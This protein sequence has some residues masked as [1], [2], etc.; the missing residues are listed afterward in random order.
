MLDYIWEDRFPKRTNPRMGWFDYATP[1]Y[2]FITICTKEKRCYFG[3]P[4]MLNDAGHVA[5]QMLEEIPNHF[6]G[7]NVDKFV[8]MPNH[9]HAILVLNDGKTKLSDIIGQYKSAVTRHLHKAGWN[10]PIWQTSFHDHVIRDQ[11]GYEK[12]WTY[13]DTNPIRWNDDCFYTE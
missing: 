1:G 10:Q 13:I 3:Q 2:Y 11:M 12:I 5:Q 6:P 8:V 7:T 4:Q 9:I